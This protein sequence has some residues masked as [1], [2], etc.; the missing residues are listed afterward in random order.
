MKKKIGLFATIGLMLVLAGCSTTPIEKDSEKTA[1]TGDGHYPVTI[2]NYSYKK[3]PIELTYDKAPEK[4]LAVYQNSI[5]TLL[6]LG[7]EDKIV[8]ASG[9]DNPVKEEYKEA[10]GKINYLTEFA[11]T[12]ESVTMLEPDLILSWYS[13][14]GEKKLGEVT[15]WNNKGVNTYM[16]LNTVSGMPK[17]LENEYTDILN[18]GKIFNVEDRANVIVDEMKVAV[19]KAKA[20]GEKQTVKP[21]VMVVEE[22][23]DV[24]I[25]YGEA[26]LAGD[27]IKSLG[28]VLANPSGEKIGAEDIVNINPDLLFVV[29]MDRENEGMEEKS[30]KSF[31]ENPVYKS[32][33]AVENNKVI[34]IQL[35]EMYC[36]GIRTID[37]LNVFA[38]GLYPDLD[39]K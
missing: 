38:K 10:F 29:Y 11:P 14:F 25:N 18:L 36:S 27:M 8:A 7:L 15:E 31:T 23:G 12:K 5:E 39:V 2:S 30:V 37:G 4:V 32:I 6:A 22:Q 34:P 20:Y 28:G 21:T 35:G 13:Y 26:T 3:E 24:M 33:S 1:T 16:A 19:D 17:V 9:L